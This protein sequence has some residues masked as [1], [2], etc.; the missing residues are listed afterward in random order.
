MLQYKTGDG[1]LF[2]G[3][4]AAAVVVAIWKSG[5]FPEPTVGDYMRGVAA[6]VKEALNQDI[7]TSSATAF[8][9]GLERVGLLER[10]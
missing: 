7:D 10:I 8:L 3:P 1:K 9:A 6:R 5:F 2:E 4:H